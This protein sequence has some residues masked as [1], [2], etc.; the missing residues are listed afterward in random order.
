LQDLGEAPLTNLT[1]TQTLLFKIHPA[2]YHSQSNTPS[3]NNNRYIQISTATGLLNPRNR[4]FLLHLAVLITYIVSRRNRLFK[5]RK[6]R[7]LLPNGLP[8]I[9]NWDIFLCSND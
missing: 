8:T 4:E 5:T 9:R 3:D 7:K 6:C 1:T 2:F